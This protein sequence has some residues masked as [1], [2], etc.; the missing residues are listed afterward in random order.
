MNRI[1]H[2]ISKEVN[3]RERRRQAVHVQMGYAIR[4]AIITSSKRHHTRNIYFYSIIDR[5]PISLP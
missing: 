4:H 3:K 5:I 1:E 2:D